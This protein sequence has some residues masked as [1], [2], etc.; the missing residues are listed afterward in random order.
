MAACAVAEKG[1]KK[2]CLLCGDRF[3]NAA[4]MIPVRPQERYGGCRTARSPGGRGPNRGKGGKGKGEAAPKPKAQAKAAA[5]QGQKLAG[6]TPPWQSTSPTT[7]W[8]DVAT[9]QGG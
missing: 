6:A 7:R 2:I 1:E 5:A 9:T 8:A 3:R 4:Q